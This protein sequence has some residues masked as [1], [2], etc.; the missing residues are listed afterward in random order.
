MRTGSQRR[1]LIEVTGTPWDGYFYMVGIWAF[2]FHFA[3]DGDLSRFSADEIAL[4]IDYEGD[5]DA[6]LE[7]LDG[8][9]VTC[10]KI[11]DWESW[12][13]AL[14]SSRRHE[15]ARKWEQRKDGKAAEQEKMSQGQTGTMRDNGPEEKREDLKPPIVPHDKAKNRARER[16]ESEFWPRWPNKKGTKQQTRERFEKLSVKNQE[17]CIVAEGF[18]IEALTAGLIEPQ[19]QYRSEN[20]VG[21]S[22]EYWKEWQDGIPDYLKP[23]RHDQTTA[24]RVQACFKCGAEMS[25]DDMLDRGEFV[26]GRGWCHKTCPDGEEKR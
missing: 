6:L 3:H 10:G 26:E 4:G 9:F 20:F 1:R 11:G 15:S 23:K 14:F 22:K 21:G 24:D 25:P 16:F 8:L 2:A 13:G 19:R 5:S 18:Y 12:G 7:A 17:K